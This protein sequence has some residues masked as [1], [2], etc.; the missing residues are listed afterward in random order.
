MTKQQDI[1]ECHECGQQLG[2]HDMWFE[3]D[4][5]EKCNES[6]KYPTYIIKFDFLIHSVVFEFT[7]TEADEWQSDG[8]YDYHFSE[9]YG[10]ICVY[11][12]ND[13]TETIHKVIL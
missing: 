6:K 11:K 10:E 7:P 5:C 12:I 2:R 3:G 13:V 4:I 9:E 8:V 1:W